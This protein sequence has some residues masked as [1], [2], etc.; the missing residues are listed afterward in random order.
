MRILISVSLLGLL[1]CMVGCGGGGAP[2]IDT[3]QME[4]DVS[5][6]VT[7]NIT[8]AAQDACILAAQPA[9]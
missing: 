5:A 1:F 9:W 8:Q 2:S 4:A 7:G 6:C 3:D